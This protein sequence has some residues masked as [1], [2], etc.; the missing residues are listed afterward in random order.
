MKDEMSS[1][2]SAIKGAY[3]RG[4]EDEALEPIVAVDRD[5]Q[6]FGRIQQGDSVIFY[7][8]RGE[9]EVE[10]T[11]SLI[12]NNFSHFPIAKEL[13]LN[14]V[15]M[16][17]YSSSLDVKVAFPPE[18]RIA[19]TFVEVVTQAGLR[20]LKIAESE[21]AVHVGFFLNGKTETIFSGE[22]RTVVPSPHGI[23]NYALT[24]E[25]S[26]CHV[27]EEIFQNLEESAYDVIIANLC[28]VDVI[29][30]IEDR[31]AV[32]KAIESVDTELGRIAE[33]CQEKE[34]TLVITADH[35]TVEEWH[36]PDG[37]INTG[38]TKNLVPFI[39]SDDSLLP[40]QELKMKNLGELS[41]VAPTLLNLLNITQP[42]EMTCK[43]L[44]Q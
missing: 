35:G 33:F 12:K 4:E 11:E 24:P 22:E 36:Y 41:D 1:M 2:V 31:H 6:S 15:T 20:L 43:S 25:M 3:D 27:T 23:D 39:I 16:I 9:R 10:I 32:L 29:G 14:F 38:H 18:K 21:K 13:D 40:Q 30:H 26:A 7:D 5:E 17:E 34:I 42:E 44:I 37:K 19:N 8:I 28:N